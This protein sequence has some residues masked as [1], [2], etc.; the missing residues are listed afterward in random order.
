VWDL[1]EV[2][3]GNVLTSS[4]LRYKVRLNKLYVLVT[5]MLRGLCDFSKLINWLIIIK[6][7]SVSNKRFGFNRSINEIISPLTSTSFNFSFLIH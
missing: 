7:R 1:I 2:L 4:V 5:Y 3:L 6:T